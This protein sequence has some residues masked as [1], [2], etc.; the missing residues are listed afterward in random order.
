MTTENANAQLPAAAHDLHVDAVSLRLPTLWTSNV[1]AWF[2]HIETQFQLRNITRDRTKFNHVMASLDEK[3]FDRINDLLDVVP[4]DGAYEFLKAEIIE[5][6][7][8]S[9]E[10]RIEMLLDMPPSDRRPSEQLQYMR[11]IFRPKKDDVW[12]RVVFWRSLPREISAIFAHDKTVSLDVLARRADKYHARPPSSN[13]SS[14]ARQPPFARAEREPDTTA[15]AAVARQQSRPNVRRDDR[16]K[17]DGTACYYHAMF[18]SKA[19][20]CRSPCSFGQKALN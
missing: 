5:R 18:G 13:V 11:S 3:T 10:E 7:D 20:K 8:V 2:R 19:Q 16:K 14:V 4:D 12:F 9:E 6:Y 17:D 15:V 1:T